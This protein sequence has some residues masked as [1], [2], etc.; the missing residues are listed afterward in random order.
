MRLHALTDGPEDGRPLVLLH[1]LLGSAASGWNVDGG[2]SIPALSLCGPGEGW[3]V[4]RIDLPNHGDSPRQATFSLASVAADVK[5]TVEA[6][7]YASAVFCGH[8]LGGKVAMQLACTFPTFVER[9]VVLDMS[10]RAFPPFHLFLLRA[11]KDLPVATVTDLAQ[12]DEEL[13]V[14]APKARDRAYVFTNLEP[15]GEGHFRWR[16]DLDNLIE[17]YR[18][19]SEAGLSGPPYPGEARFVMGGASP[20]KFWKDE[21]LIKEYFPNATIETRAGIDHLGI[22]A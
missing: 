14:L 20:F 22:L 1:G 19:V 10:P 5:E 3:R 4:I 16:C 2:E 7:G 6:L 21:A 8:S 15:D 17:N 13:A 11:C 9:L 18:V 12:L